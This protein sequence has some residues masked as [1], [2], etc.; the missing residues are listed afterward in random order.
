MKKILF[1]LISLASFSAF[2]QTQVNFEFHHFLG[3]DPFAIDQSATTAA[4]YELNFNRLEFYV[5]EIDLVH[6]G[7]QVTRVKDIYLLEN[8]KSRQIHNLGSFPVTDLEEVRFYI[9]VDSVANHDDPLK[10]SIDH[11]LAPKNPSMHWGW[12]SGYRFVV[13]EGKTG[14]G[15]SQIYE[16]HALGDANYHQIVIPMDRSAENG[17]LSIDVAADYLK[18]FKTVDVSSGKI[19][20]SNFGEAIPFLRDFADNVFS[21]YS[22]PITGLEENQA[23]NKM[24]VYP[25]PGKSGESSIRWEQ[26]LTSTV[27]IQLQDAS[28]RMISTQIIESGSTGMNLPE[29]G[30]GVYFISVIQEG[31]PLQVQ[32]WVVSNE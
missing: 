27:Q 4:N 26:P 23:E 1:T 14:A 29:V 22:A 28:G 19:L 3:D 15:L 9:G 7:G 5:A 12:S 18:A 31:K 2:A 24:V 30:S 8:V 10:Y 21:A 16:I 11:P 25:N 6:D 17:T 32:R 13:M 20:H